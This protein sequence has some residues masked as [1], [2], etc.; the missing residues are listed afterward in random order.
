MRGGA[1]T[2]SREDLAYLQRLRRVTIKYYAHMFNL[3]SNGEQ[4]TRAVYRYQLFLGDMKEGDFLCVNLEKHDKVQQFTTEQIMREHWHTCHGIPVEE[5]MLPMVVPVLIREP[6]KPTTRELGLG[7]GSGNP[8][9]S[10]PPAGVTGSGGGAG[11][12]TDPEQGPS[13]AGGFLVKGTVP[14][15]GAGL[16]QGQGAGPGKGKPRGRGR[17]GAISEDRLKEFALLY[18]EGKPFRD[19]PLKEK[20][21]KDNSKKVKPSKEKPGKGKPD[22]D[23]S[24][25]D[26]GSKGK[27]VYVSGVNPKEYKADS[28]SKTV[29]D[30]V[31]SAFL[32][33]EK[34]NS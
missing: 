16:V 33:E 34:S 21:D 10:G 27:P 28:N 24:A 20:A 4:F 5:I 23:P 31:A 15:Q 14:N 2:L 12:V 17:L 9:P 18:G 26:T 6:A 8:G 3:L 32:T 11:Q 25:T 22:V 13:A 30:E 29:D 1:L 7:S 19:V